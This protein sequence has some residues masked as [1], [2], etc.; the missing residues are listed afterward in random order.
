[1]FYNK[2][3][4]FVVA[5]FEEDKQSISVCTRSI[6]FFN[7]LFGDPVGTIFQRCENTSQPFVNG[8]LWHGRNRC[9]GPWTI[10]S[11]LR[12]GSAFT[13]HAWLAGLRSWWRLGNHWLG[14]L[15]P[16]KFVCLLW[17]RERICLGMC[18]SQNFLR[19]GEM[20]KK[21]TLPHKSPKSSK[22]TQGRCTIILSRFFVVVTPQTDI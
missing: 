13:Q 7:E 8:A 15:S 11:S 9:W 3:V 16:N 2:P 19:R 17:L 22:R 6:P 20:L 1:M 12:I 18:L 14:H 5:F 4:R 10:I 21:S